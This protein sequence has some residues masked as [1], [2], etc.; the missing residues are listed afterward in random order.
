MLC[1]PDLMSAYQLGALD[2]ESVQAVQL[3]MIAHC[4]LMGDRMA[5]LDTPPGLNPQQVKEWRVDKAGLR[6]GLRGR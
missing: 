2:L 6:L 1:I 3:T 5:I 4:E